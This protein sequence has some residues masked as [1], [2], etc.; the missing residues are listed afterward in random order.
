MI[1]FLKRFYKN[2]K[3]QIIELFT[4]KILQ[5]IKVNKIKY[6]MNK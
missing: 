5:N 3:K 1:I 4:S 2:S 6:S